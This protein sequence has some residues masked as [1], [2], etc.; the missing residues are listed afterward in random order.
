MFEE[1]NV[2]EITLKAGVMGAYE[3]DTVWNTN[4]GPLQFNQ[5]NL[6]A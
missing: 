4:S 3:R 1:K 2:C 6:F 5:E